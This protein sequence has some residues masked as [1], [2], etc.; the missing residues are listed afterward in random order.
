MIRP[1][2]GFGMA[3]AAMLSIAGCGSPASGPL[4]AL[5]ETDIG[6]NAPVIAELVERLCIR[7][8]TKPDGFPDLLRATGWSSTQTQQAD[9]GTNLDVWSLPHIELAHSRTPIETPKARVWTCMVAVDAQVAPSADD[10]VKALRPRANREISNVHP[11]DWQWKPAPLTEAHITINPTMTGGRSVF[12]QFT[13]VK[14]F[15]ALFG[16]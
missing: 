9:Q 16:S 14:P 3:S 12:V 8:T 4:P 7:G 15:N 2:I 13:D 5:S 10:L 6:A 11:T 1:A